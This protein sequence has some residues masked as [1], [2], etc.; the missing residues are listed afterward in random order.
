MRDETRQELDALLG[1]REERLAR[2][3]AAEDEKHAE[4]NTFVRQ[5]LDLQE[6][7]IRPAME[8]IGKQLQQHGY[9]F[10]IDEGTHRLSKGQRDLDSASIYMKVL[11]PGGKLSQLQ[12]KE[13][14]FIGFTASAGQR[15]YVR[16][17]RSVSLPGKGRMSEES[18]E[19]QL[20]QIGAEAVEREILALVKLVIEQG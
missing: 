19:Y 15:P 17:E 10:R 12:S 11:P 13:V 6:S 4:G 8:E 18:K 20:G 16:V 14:P 1:A 3:H 2:E 5:F 9:V 7:V